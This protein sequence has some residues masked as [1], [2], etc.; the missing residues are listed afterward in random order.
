M[1]LPCDPS[2]KPSISHS[3]SFKVPRCPLLPI[4]GPAG[5]SWQVLSGASRFGCARCQGM[6]NTPLSRD[7]D[8]ERAARSRGN[9]TSSGAGGNTPARNVLYPSCRARTPTREMKG[10]VGSGA[11]CPGLPTVD[12]STTSPG[13]I[14][15][16]HQIYHGLAC[17]RRGELGSVCSAV[18]LHA[19]TGLVG[20]GGEGGVPGVHGRCRRVL[21]ST[22][23]GAWLAPGWHVRV[24]R[25]RLAC[26]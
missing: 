8:A 10:K 23:A 4:I 18:S 11:H 25:T 20:A 17:I 19:G 16:P 26:G 13:G 7:A 1:R 22:C 15:A 5:V 9:L 12:Y 21:A 24:A 3:N 6:I 14:P 2:G